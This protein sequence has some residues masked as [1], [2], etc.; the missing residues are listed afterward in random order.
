MS[1]L[2]DLLSLLLFRLGMNSSNEKVMC[3][4]M[5]TIGP[6]WGDRMSNNMEMD[7]LIKYHMTI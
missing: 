3:R 6:K 7:M 2:F 1:I 5:S 4:K